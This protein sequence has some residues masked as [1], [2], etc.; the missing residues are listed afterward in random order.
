MTVNEVREIRERQSL[1]T[2][3]MSTDE[4]HEY[5]SVGAFEMQILIGRM[6]EHNASVSASASV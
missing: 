1:E 3:G 2:A 5:Y 4:L 6:R